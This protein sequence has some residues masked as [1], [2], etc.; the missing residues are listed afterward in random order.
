MVYK[1]LKNGTIVD[2]DSNIFIPTD[3]RNRHYQSYIE[4]LN[5]GNTPQQDA[6]EPAEIPAFVTPYQARVALARAGLLNK[7]NSV[8]EGGSEEMKLAWNYATV[9]E[10]NSPFI[11]A[12]APTLA[13]TDERIDELFVQAAAI[14]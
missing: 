5:A 11:T 10:R 9:I 7:V 14:T 2:V 3:P 13:L 1:V 12:L 6:S 4:W 8:V